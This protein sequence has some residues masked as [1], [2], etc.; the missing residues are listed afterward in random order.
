[1]AHKAR[2]ASH[3]VPKVVPEALFKPCDF[4]SSA[5]AGDSLVKIGGPLASALTPVRVEQKDDD[6]VMVAG[7]SDTRAL[8]RMLGTSGVNRI[9]TQRLTFA[10]PTQLVTNSL[11]VVAYT[12]NL[13]ALLSG[14]GEYTALT[15]LYDSLYI[16]SITINYIPNFGKNQLDIANNIWGGALI[17]GVDWDSS[18]T[19]TSLEQVWRYDQ[20]G[21]TSLCDNTAKVYKHTFV[22]P[23]SR[24][25]TP[26]ESGSAGQLGSLFAYSSIQGTTGVQAGPLMVEMV[27]DFRQRY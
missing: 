19:P 18:V 13:S 9:N 23:S 7:T 21:L 5:S 16:R 15:S 10:L 14:S 27:V 11:G 26:W 24:V 25:P 1:M 2:A 20:R 4:G 22:Q 6:L 17:F 8:R 3:A 12:T